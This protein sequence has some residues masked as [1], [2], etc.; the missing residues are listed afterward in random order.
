MLGTEEDTAMSRFMVDLWAN[1]ATFR[2]PTPKGSDG[3]F[4]GD[5][6]SELKKP[7]MAAKVGQ[8]DGEDMAILSGGTISSDKSERFFGRIKF[9]EKLFKDLGLV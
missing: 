2:D 1:F 7:W 5:S 8:K 9:W 3:N 6:L 4:I